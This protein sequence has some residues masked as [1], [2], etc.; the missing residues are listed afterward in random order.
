MVQ[1]SLRFPQTPTNGD[2][3]SKL[4][5]RFDALMKNLHVFHTSVFGFDETLIHVNTRLHEVLLRGF[6]GDAMTNC[7]IFFS[8]IV[9]KGPGIVKRL[10]IN[11]IETVPYENLLLYRSSSLANGIRPLR[12]STQ[13]V[14]ECSLF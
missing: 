10:K 1:L 3:S 4:P 12:Y 5:E 14:A 7:S 13:R 8:Q 2:F 11:E 6:R 9:Q